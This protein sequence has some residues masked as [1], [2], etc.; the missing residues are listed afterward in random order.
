M[1]SSLQTD[2]GRDRL[3]KHVAVIH[4]SGE[5]SLLERKLSNVLLLHAYDNLLTVR[6]HSMPVQL[7]MEFLGWEAGQNVPKLKEALK[8][9]ATTPMEFDVMG[10]MAGT[11]EEWGVSAILSGAEIKRGV[12]TYRYDERLAEKLYNPAIYGTIHAGVQRRFAGKSTLALYENCVRYLRV[13][14]TGPW[15]LS[16]IRRLLGATQEY[17]SDFR[18]LNS[19]VI[20]PA[21]KEINKES[22][23]VLT[24][25]LVKA[26]RTVTAV[27]FLVEAGPQASLLPPDEIPELGDIRESETYKK[28]RKHGIGEKLALSFVAEDPERAD[29]IVQLAEEKD[30]KGEI[31][32][33]TAGFIRTLYESGAD[34]KPTEYQ[35]RQRQA[36]QD[37]IARRQAEAAADLRSEFERSAKAQ[38]L[39]ALGQEELLALARKFITTDEGRAYAAD[40]AEGKQ[41]FFTGVARVEFKR[42]LPSQLGVK[43]DDTAFASWLASRKT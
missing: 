22:D 1:S 37:A 43:I 6:E 11:D 34:V 20:Q 5:L 42:W 38:A 24:P 15:E 29:R 7:L 9:L 36:A 19:K 23:I 2:R 10:D 35:T 3:K 40:F 39:K 31:K 21:V 33:T 14:S 28:L 25:E 27:R 18:R 4:T 26:G 13:G 30:G 32:K 41:E 17:Y 8:R 16:T 12:C